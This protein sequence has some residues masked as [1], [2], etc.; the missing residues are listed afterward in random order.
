MR[1]VLL[2]ARRFEG[3]ERILMAIEDVTELRRADEELRQSQKMEAIGFLAAG[4]AHD[5]NN[6]LTGIMGNASLLLDSLPESEP[7]SSTLRSIISGG[8]RAAELTRQLL[9]YAGKGRFYLERV[10]LSKVVIQTGRL[11]QPSIPGNVQVRLGSAKGPATA[12]GRSESGANSRNPARCPD[13]CLQRIRRRGSRS[14]FRRKG[15]SRF[16]PKA[17]HREATRPEGKECI[18]AVGS[19]A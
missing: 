14:T 11:I 6:L 18:G 12:S 3:E 4:I 16:L 15:D 7:I 10:D 17:V 1:V 8:E 5:F 2:N 9:A 13:R 19:G